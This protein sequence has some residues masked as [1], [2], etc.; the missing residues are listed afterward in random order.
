MLYAEIAISRIAME[1]IHFS[2]IKS[3]ALQS[4]IIS[5]LDEDQ[6]PMRIVQ[7]PAHGAVIIKTTYFIKRRY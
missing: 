1:V 4:S 2:K 5:T 6:K 3:L 7:R